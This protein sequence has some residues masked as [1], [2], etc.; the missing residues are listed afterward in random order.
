[1]ALLPNPIRLPLTAGRGQ[2]WSF[3]DVPT[4]GLRARTVDVW[5]PPE[6][7]SDPGARFPVLYM[8]DGQNCFNDDRANFGAAWGAHLAADRLAA[9]GHVAPHIIV[10][11]WST[12]DRHAEY[13]PTAP[14]RDIPGAPALPRYEDASLCRVADPERLRSDAY[15]RFLVEDLKPAIDATFRTRPERTA[16]TV[17]G[18]SMGGMISLYALTCYPE[19][20]AGAGCLSTHWPSGGNRAIDRLIGALPDP[21]P[22][23]R[24]GPRVYFDYGDRT[25]DTCYEPYQDRADQRMRARG[26]RFAQ[27]W[28]TLRFPD[29]AHNEQAWRTRLEV[30]L[31]FLWSER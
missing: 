4:A 26:Y 9:A 22:D 16:T 13:M 29:A 19:V 2:A 7:A 8:H 14:M 15:L 3:P 17:A 28:I 18:S 27:D 5:L 12:G 30:P 24:E 23:P 21:S 6:Y 31:A 25:L 11:V 20:F 1:M 10:A